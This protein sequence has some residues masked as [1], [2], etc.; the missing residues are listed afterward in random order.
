MKKKIEQKLISIENQIGVLENADRFAYLKDDWKI[1]H[2]QRQAVA[3][4]LA[5]FPKTTES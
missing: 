3:E 5:M 1:L 4:I 2:A